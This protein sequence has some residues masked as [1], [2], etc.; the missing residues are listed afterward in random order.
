[1]LA[2]SVRALVEVKRNGDW[3]VGLVKLYTVKRRENTSRKCW[4]GVCV[5]WLRLRGKGTGGLVGS[6]RIKE[7]SEWLYR[8]RGSHGKGKEL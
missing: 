5:R 3:W 6:S 1:M 2:R 4:P 7:S 8:P